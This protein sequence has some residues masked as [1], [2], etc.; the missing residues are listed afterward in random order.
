[1][2]N[3]KLPMIYIMVEDTLDIGD[4]ITV[5]TEEW[6]PGERAHHFDLDL[7]QITH[8]RNEMIKRRIHVVSFAVLTK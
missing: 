7:E 1:M 3:R 4:E 2:S 6:E 5:T 8:V